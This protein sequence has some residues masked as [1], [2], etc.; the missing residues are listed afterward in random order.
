VCSILFIFKASHIIISM[1]SASLLIS[2][3]PVFRLEHVEQYAYPRLWIKVS[4]G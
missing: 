1:V 3:P 4:K 2:A